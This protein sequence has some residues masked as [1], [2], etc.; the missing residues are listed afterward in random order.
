MHVLLYF[1]L[2]GFVTALPS[3][4]GGQPNFARCLAVSW[5]GTLYIHFRGLFPPDGILPGAKFTLRPSLAFSYIVALLHGTS[6]AGVS[7]ALRHGTMNGI[8]EHLQ[9]AIRL[10]G[11]HD[12][13]RPTL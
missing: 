8:T 10:G 7:Q 6:A 4:N 11:H 2:V 3:L 12:D 5:A 1:A 9:R 13:H